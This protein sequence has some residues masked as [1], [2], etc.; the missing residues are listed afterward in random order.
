MEKDFLINMLTALKGSQF[1]FYL[2]EDLIKGSY[3]R[4]IKNK[5]LIT[6]E[7]PSFSEYILKI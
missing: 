1:F 4:K 5:I 3:G 7:R 2:G 6:Y